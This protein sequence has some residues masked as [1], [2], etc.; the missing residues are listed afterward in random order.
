MKSTGFM[1][2]TEKT[3]FVLANIIFV[4]KKTSLGNEIKMYKYKYFQFDIFSAKKKCY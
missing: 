1:N 3:D 2:F 4:Q